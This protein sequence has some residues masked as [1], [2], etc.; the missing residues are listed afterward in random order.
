MTYRDVGLVLIGAGVVIALTPIVSFWS[1][2]CY[3]VLVGW[4][5]RRVWRSYAKRAAKRRTLELAEM[6]RGKRGTNSYGD[7]PSA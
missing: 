4:R 2:W 7:T 3:R 6:E 1:D 5:Q